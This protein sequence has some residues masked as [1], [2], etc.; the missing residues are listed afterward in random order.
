MKLHKRVLSD[1]HKK[2]WMR[3]LCNFKFD[4]RFVKVYIP[5][6]AHNG[7]RTNRS[8]PLT[9]LSIHFLEMRTPILVSKLKEKELIRRL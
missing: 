9:K 2:P 7:E 3:I 4:L 6:E 5:R 8:L 1:R